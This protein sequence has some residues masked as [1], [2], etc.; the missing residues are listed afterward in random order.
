MKFPLPFFGKFYFPGGREISTQTTVDYEIQRQKYFYEKSIKYIKDK[1]KNGLEIYKKNFI[2][3]STR[4]MERRNSFFEEVNTLVPYL[5]LINHNNN[6]NS[7]FIYDEKRDG[8]C[9]YSIKN[10][11]KNEEITISYG[12]L[13]NI[14][15]DICNIGFKDFISYA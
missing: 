5:D 14:V 3:V 1:L 12:K 15:L 2:L 7:Y 11:N 13:N 8:F 9:L 6:Y 4:N 10:I